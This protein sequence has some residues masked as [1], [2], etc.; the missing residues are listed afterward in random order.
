MNQSHYK[1]CMIPL[2]ETAIKSCKCYAE[3]WKV[4]KEKKNPFIQ[5]DYSVEKAF[6]YRKYFADNKLL[7][8]FCINCLHEVV[9]NI[10]MRI[11]E[12]EVSM[13]GRA[14][15]IFKFKH[16]S[17]PL[18]EVCCIC[19]NFMIHRFSSNFFIDV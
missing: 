19:V 17:M 2:K 15:C 3:Y 14:L 12:F 18:G 11:I 16:D 8:H 5:F 7:Y 4:L 1:E 13:K 6:T 10:P 9:M